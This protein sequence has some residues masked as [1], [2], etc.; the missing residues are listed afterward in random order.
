MELAQIEI[1]ENSVWRLPKHW[2][3][4]LKQVEAQ[5][6]ERAN[7]IVE[8]QASGQVET[9]SGV[10]LGA[11]MDGTMIYIRGEDWKELKVGCFFKVEQAPTLD[12]ETMDWIDLAHARELPYVSHLGGPE[13]FGKENVDGVQAASLAQGK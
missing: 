12:P 3:E 10:R 7:G 1:L 5:E 2:G 13:A 6:D 4:A 9:K 8:S 11:S